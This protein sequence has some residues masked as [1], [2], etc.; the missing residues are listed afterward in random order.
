MNI[1]G[2]DK[3]VFLSDVKA[4]DDTLINFFLTSRRIVM[5]GAG[6]IKQD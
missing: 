3:M 2:G 1:F 6:F 4:F 5:G